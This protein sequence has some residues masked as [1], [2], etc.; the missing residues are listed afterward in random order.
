[1]LTDRITV[2]QAT[3]QELTPEDHFSA[4]LSVIFTDDLRNQHGDADAT[5]VYASPTLGD[6]KL[7]LADPS[8]EESRRLFAHYLWNAGVWA[9]ARIEEASLAYVEPAATGKVVNQEAVWNVKG[10]SVLELGAGKPTA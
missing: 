8:K 10:E 9:A 1:M 5:I 6:I 7:S 2:L 4:S 3:S